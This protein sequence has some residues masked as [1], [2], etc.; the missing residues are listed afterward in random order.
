[1]AAVPL[2]GEN[3]TCRLEE[4]RVRVV[5]GKGSTFRIADVDR[6]LRRL[7]E[8]ARRGYRNT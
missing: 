2:N 8:A 3:V 1:M 5:A 7:I 4:I 6:H